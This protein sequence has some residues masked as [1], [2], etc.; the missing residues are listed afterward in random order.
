MGFAAAPGRRGGN[1]NRTAVTSS[2]PARRTCGARATAATAAPSTASD[3]ASFRVHRAGPWGA[4]LSSPGACPTTGA[5][6]GAAA[7]PSQCPSNVTRPP[8]MFPTAILTSHAAIERR[9]ARVPVR[10]AGPG[11]RCVCR[12]HHRH[13]QPRARARGTHR[14][15]GAISGATRGLLPSPRRAAFAVVLGVAGPPPEPRRRR[16][17]G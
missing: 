10:G 13:A 5:A 15:A 6:Q 8:S 14:R 3:D 11:D 16:R 4:R 1:P 7:A 2:R 9:A 12:Y 17:V